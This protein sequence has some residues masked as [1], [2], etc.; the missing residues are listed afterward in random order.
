MYI[1]HVTNIYIYSI[2]IYILYISVCVFLMSVHI[3][4]LCL[5]SL[6]NASWGKDLHVEGVNFETYDHLFLRPSIGSPVLG[7][8]GRCYMAGGCGGLIRARIRCGLVGHVVPQL[9]LWPIVFLRG[10]NQQYGYTL[11]SNTAI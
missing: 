6:V 7:P 3:S 1:L 2:Y 9:A 5:V 10:L 4:Q 11:Q 8:W